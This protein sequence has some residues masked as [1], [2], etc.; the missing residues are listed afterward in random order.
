M[1][2]STRLQEPKYWLLGIAAAIAALHLAL[3][4]RAGNSELFATSAL[5]W[6]TAGS[7]FWDRRQSL[8]LESGWAGSLL[9]TGL[10]AFFFLRSAS[11]PGSDIF[12]KISPFFAVLGLCWLAS[13][14][15]SLKQYW[16]ELTVFGLL[17]LNPVLENL[18]QL[19]DLSTLTAKAATF[20]LWY[21]GFQIQRQGIFLHLPTGSVQVYEMCSGLQSIV[22]MINVAVLF[23]LMFPLKSLAQKITCIVVA[24]II[25]FVVN[26]ARVCL[27]ANLVAQK[28]S[29]EYWHTGNGSL[30]FSMIS[31]A[32]FGGFCWL[33][34]LRTPQKPLD[35]GAE[36]NG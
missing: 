35:K 9:G 1:D 19:L 14:I 10:L 30:I 7:L 4:D 5:F 34:F 24:I 11:L 16:Q 21:L 27:M 13:G 31:V 17:A 3:I 2:W 18:L 22:Q 25:G 8:T 23:L 26:A 12:L 32:L 36:A 33:A 15:K 28:T 29:F 6:I 20:I